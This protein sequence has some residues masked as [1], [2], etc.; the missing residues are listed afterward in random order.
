M[1]FRVKDINLWLQDGWTDVGIL[2]IFGMRG[3]GKTTIAK[4]VYNSNFKKFER[5]SFLENIREISEEPNGLIR[6]QKHLLCDVLNKKKVKV[7]SV[8]EGVTR[9]KDALQSKRVLLVLD[10]MDHMDQMDAILGMKDISFIL[11]VKSS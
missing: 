6:L 1:D 2:A 11:E 10:D 4:F 8:G 7:H 5:S 9:I 3:I